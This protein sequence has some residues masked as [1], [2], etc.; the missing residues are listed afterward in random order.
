MFDYSKLRGKM[1]EKDV[2]QEQLAKKIGI[3]SASLREKLKG[4]RPYF[5]ADEMVAIGLALGI[6]RELDEYFLCL[7]T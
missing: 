1:R 3:S 6:E 2:T 7:K 5:K 4:E